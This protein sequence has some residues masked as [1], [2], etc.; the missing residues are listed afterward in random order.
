MKST[1]LLLVAA[2]FLMGCP[3]K[4]QTRSTDTMY[5]HLPAEPK[6]F[7]AFAGRSDG[8]SARILR[9]IFDSLL[10]TDKD[11]YE[12]IPSLAESFSV[13]KDGKVFTFK[14]REGATFTDGHPL[15]TED[16]KFSFDAIFDDKYK[17]I[18]SRPYYE[19]I[20]K[21]EIV[22]KLTIKFYAK[23]KYFQ[24]LGFIGSL[25]VIPK[26]IYETPKKEHN[27]NIVGSGPWM[28]DE[29][30]QG[31][32]IT[33]KKN[34]NWWGKDVEYYKDHFKVQK[35]KI[36][37]IKEDKVVFESLKKGDLDYSAL[38][39]E[40]YIKQTE[41]KPW[42]DTVHKEIVEN[43][44]PTSLP[45]IGWNLKKDL[46]KDKK[47]RQALTHLYDRDTLV[48]KFL[49]DQ[50]VPAAGPWHHLNPAANPNRKALPFD[51]KKAKN[52]LQEAGWEDADKNGVLEKGDKEFRFVLLNPNADYEKYFTVYKEELKKAGIDMTITNLE[53]NAFQRKMDEQEFDALFLVWGAGSIHVDPKQIWHSD[54]AKTGGSNFISY[55]NKRVDE[56]ID[57]GRAELN[58]ER[59]YKMFR[60]VYDIIADDAPYVFLWYNKA[61]FYG[62]NDRIIRP[63]P[64]YNYTV[65][66]DL[67]SI[68][69]EAE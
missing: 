53:W 1:V 18:S 28:L 54:S 19:N 26:H 11:T 17:L 7:D 55:S 34:P 61:V 60:E 64:F 4:K 10:D 45:F 58:N 56:L 2:S 48:K 49:Y 40:Q 62:Y 9:Q 41:G 6:T 42:G 38:N 27:Y 36:R 33:L 31:R 67:W 65:G 59:R 51:P 14:I 8:Y 15:T 43:K 52:L 39:S 20:E 21:A 3:S 63:K 13:S 66:T 68:R 16:I 5:L 12:E 35:K 29:Y 46:F 44:A 32:S 25:M 50:A 22:D 37:F 24:T 69:A 30:K 57:K 47:V 23:K